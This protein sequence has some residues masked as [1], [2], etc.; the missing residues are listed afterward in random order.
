MSADEMN[1]VEVD[2]HADSIFGTLESVG[3]VEI[4]AEEHEASVG[5]SETGSDTPLF[6][7]PPP[8]EVELAQKRRNRF[9][10]LIALLA[11]VGV[12]VGV[13]VYFGVND[14]NSRGNVSA[15]EG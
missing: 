8:G 5:A 14:N 9:L 3:S 12:A 10:A 15:I 7:H 11:I 13:G 2:E 6:D 1:V 4:T